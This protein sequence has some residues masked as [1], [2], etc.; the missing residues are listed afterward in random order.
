MERMGCGKEQGVYLWLKFSTLSPCPA[1]PRLVWLFFLFSSPLTS[2]S[3]H[4][5]LKFFECI[6][7][8]D[9]I[10][11]QGRLWIL[12]VKNP[13]ALSAACLS[14]YLHMLV[15]RATR[16]GQQHDRCLDRC[17]WR[18]YRLGRGPGLGHQRLLTQMDMPQIC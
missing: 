16:K 9:Y 6:L 7:I 12:F 8:F 10:P 17:E 11:G 3:L 18:E 15:G 1:Y 14:A 2:P 13:G 4:D 5:G